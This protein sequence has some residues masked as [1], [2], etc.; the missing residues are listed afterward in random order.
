MFYSY[1]GPTADAAILHATEGAYLEA[2]ASGH[3]DTPAPE[4]WEATPEPAKRGPG[5]PPKAAT[6]PEGE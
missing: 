4:A 6:A 1:T 5:R 3:K 2:I